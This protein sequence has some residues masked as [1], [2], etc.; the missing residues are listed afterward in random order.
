MCQETQLSVIG[1]LEGVK[2]GVNQVHSD[3]TQAHQDILSLVG[4]VQLETNQINTQ[5]SGIKESDALLLSLAQQSSA[6]II[7]LRNEFQDFKINITARLQQTLIKLSQVS[8]QL[9]ERESSL[10]ECGVEL[11]QNRANLNHAETELVE[12]ENSLAVCGTQLD[13]TKMNLNRKETE[14]TRTM[15]QLSQT[16]TSLADLEQQLADATAALGHLQVK[17]DNLSKYACLA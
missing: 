6:D 3:T 5:T 12:K 15:T 8:N 2:Q 4:Q 1:Q 14:Q 9:Q 11:K 10:E 13:Q 16:Q 17:I 7:I